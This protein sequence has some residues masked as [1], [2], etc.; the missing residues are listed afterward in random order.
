MIEKLSNPKL[1]GPFAF[2]TVV[3]IAVGAR[4]TNY[5]F[6]GGLGGLAL[7]VAGIMAGMLLVTLPKR[8]KK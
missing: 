5:D 7:F 4:L 3:L 2:V 6:W 1:R 8:D